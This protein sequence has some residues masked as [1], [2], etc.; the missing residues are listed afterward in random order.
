MN[1]NEPECPGERYAKRCVEQCPELRP[2]RPRLW[3][4]RTF[5]NW[6]KWNFRGRPT[7]AMTQHCR[8][9]IRQADS[10]ETTFVPDYQLKDWEWL[11]FDQGTMTKAKGNHYDK[12]DI[13]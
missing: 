1:S 11:N 13:S 3:P 7:V 4:S 12:K 2:S 5:W 6:I 8:G 9:T 10:E